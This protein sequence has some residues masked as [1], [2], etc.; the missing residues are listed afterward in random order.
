VIYLKGLDEFIKIFGD[1]TVLQIVEF[2]L[3]ILFLIGI[4]KQVKKHFDN[5]AKNAVERAEIEKTRDANIQEALDA[6]R[7]YPEYRKQSIEIQHKLEAQI[8]EL[9]EI[10]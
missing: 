3:A 1:I 10:H 5:K 4:Y 6:V 8:N 7:K 2:I 9:K